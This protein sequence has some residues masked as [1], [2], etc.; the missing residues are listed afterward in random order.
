M[1]VV[2]VVG[3]PMAVLEATWRC[4]WESSPLLVVVVTVWVAVNIK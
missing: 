2:I 4:R 1:V 3:G